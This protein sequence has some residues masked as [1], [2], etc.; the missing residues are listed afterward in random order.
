MSAGAARLVHPGPAAPDRRQAV[1]A[2][3]RPVAGTLPAG[4]T[5]MA[6]VGELFAAHGCRGGIVWL[7]GLVC[8]PF[9]YVLPALATDDLHGAFYSGTHAPDGPV[10]VGAS[11]ASVGWR[12]GA[13][14][15][16]CHGTWT[17]A[18]GTAMGHLLPLNSTLAEPCAVRGIGSPDA[19]FEAVADAETNFTLFAAAGGGSGPDGLI[20]RLRPEEDV[21]DAVA[22]LCAAHGIEDARVHGLGSI[23][24]VRFADGRRVPCV[25][26]EARIDEGR[27]AAGEV[28]IAVSVVD[29]DGAIHRG[30]L[31]PGANRVGVT[32][33]LLVE[34]TA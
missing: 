6:G 24:D 22:G 2:T 21:S 32:F 12:D 15:L 9:R 33:E 28:T 25:A 14:F 7:D 5:V 19:W 34:A 8:D 4:G 10:R 23:C 11:T 29:V 18:M 30:E 13:P 20:A 31:A 3:L 27:V 16:H 26:T 1:R 17:G